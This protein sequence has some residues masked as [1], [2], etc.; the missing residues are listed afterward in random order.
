MKVTI[1]PLFI[2]HVCLR[3]C[4]VVNWAAVLTVH[5][6]IVRATLV[7]SCGMKGPCETR[8][9]GRAVMK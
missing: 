5:P 9:D 6:A 3:A 7:E 2:T 8:V 4:A 1:Y